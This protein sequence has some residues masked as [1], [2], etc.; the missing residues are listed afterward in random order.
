MTVIGGEEKRRRSM[1]KYVL[2]VVVGTMGTLVV[3]MVVV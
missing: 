1:V 3:V 2:N